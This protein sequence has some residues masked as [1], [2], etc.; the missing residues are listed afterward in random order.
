[1]QVII[2]WIAINKGRT[3]LGRNFYIETNHDLTGKIYGLHIDKP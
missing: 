3:L 1:M 2:Y